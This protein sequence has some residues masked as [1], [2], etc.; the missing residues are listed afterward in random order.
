MG[1]DAVIFCKGSAVMRRGKAGAARPAPPVDTLVITG[2]GFD[3][4]QGLDTSYKRFEAYYFAN[5][6]RILKELGLEKHWRIVEEDGRE[7]RFSDVEMIYGDPFAP[8][9]LAGDFWYAFEDSLSQLD[10]ER[11]N[12]FF[13]KE[14]DDLD[15]LDLSVENARMILREAFC[16]WI[17]TVKVEEK[18]TGYRFGSNCLFVNF[19]YTDTIEKRFGVPREN[20]FHIHGQAEQKESIVFGHALHP[21]QPVDTLYELGGR[22]RGLFLVE[23]M[24]YETDKHAYLH[25][26]ELL[27]YL[28][29]RGVRLADIRH[30]YVLGHSFGPADLEYFQELAAAM[31]GKREPREEL[32]LAAMDELELLHLM[33][34]YVILTYGNDGPHPEFDKAAA[35][36]VGKQ[37]YQMEKDV[38]WKS[39]QKQ[40]KR[41]SFLRRKSPDRFPRLDQVLAV[42]P[43]TVPAKWHISY[44]SEKDKSRIRETMRKT[45]V[46]EYELY[47]SIDGCLAGFRTAEKAEAK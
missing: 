28:A 38:I 5:R 3:I 24:L 34:G 41:R 40:Y 44:Y 29:W 42:P 2:N 35:D 36:A 8:G 7:E 32:D 22:F 17:S 33:M 16:Q 20:V 15:D 6:D 14:E 13:G 9:E 30:V 45:G 39:V 10:A 18:E 19:N 37:V 27:V 43:G 12:L 25:Y 47:D 46:T 23:E 31:G 26:M 21:Q 4:W 1:T 11:I